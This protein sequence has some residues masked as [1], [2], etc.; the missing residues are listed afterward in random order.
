MIATHSIPNWFLGHSSRYSPKKIWS[1]SSICSNFGKVCHARIIL[2]GQS[3]ILTTTAPFFS[4]LPPSVPSKVTD[5]RTSLTVVTYRKKK[6]SVA[7]SKS[8]SS[9]ML[10]LCMIEYSQ[11]MDGWPFRARL[12]TLTVDNFPGV[13][14][15][16]RLYTPQ[17]S[18][19]RD[20]KL[21]SCVLQKDHKCTLKTL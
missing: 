7:H 12:F 9:Q 5:W 4:S 20:Y 18:S 8:T 11:H 1:V 2:F 19:E 6:Y 17:K 10:W 14:T 3:T 16:W 15:L 21:R 13:Q